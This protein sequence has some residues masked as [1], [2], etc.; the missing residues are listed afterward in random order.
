MKFRVAPRL[1][2]ILVSERNFLISERLATSLAS[3]LSLNFS[4]IKSF[5]YSVH[6][7]REG[8]AILTSAKTF[9][10]HYIE[11]NEKFIQF[12]KKFIKTKRSFQDG[13]VQ[14]AQQNAFATSISPKLMDRFY[15]I[16]ANQLEIFSIFDLYQSQSYNLNGGPV[17]RIYKHT[18][19]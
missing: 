5:S 19:N 7:L 2:L 9:H 3:I 8:P 1:L 14:P 17:K 16:K 10:N 15:V 11:F 13:P 4:D 12:I 18:L 6:F